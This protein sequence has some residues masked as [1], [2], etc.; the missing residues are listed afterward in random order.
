VAIGLLEGDESSARR[1]VSR[2]TTLDPLRS[3]CPPLAP[4]VFFPARSDEGWTSGCP[5][6]ARPGTAPRDAAA[7]LT[8][9]I[10]FAG[11]REESQVPRSGRPSTDR[12]LH[13]KP[14][15][16]PP[17]CRDEPIRRRPF[18][19]ERFPASRLDSVRHPQPQPGTACASQTPPVDLCL[20]NTTREHVR[21]RSILARERVFFALR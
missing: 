9:K 16:R 8:T 18:A 19:P 20:P 10:V 21:E 11:L 12:E 7:N 13:T 2:S 4:D 17:R 5:V 6:T 1:W 14:L 15:Y 3:A